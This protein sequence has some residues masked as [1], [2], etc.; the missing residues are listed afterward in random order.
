MNMQT[1]SEWLRQGWLQ[2]ELP[3]LND[4]T[5][6]EL[7]ERV[8]A[9]IYESYVLG[10]WTYAE[11]EASLETLERDVLEGTEWL[12]MPLIPEEENSDRG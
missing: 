9:H 1:A 5:R 2:G 8:G 11:A 12:G 3:A 10:F 4:A 6:E 7:I